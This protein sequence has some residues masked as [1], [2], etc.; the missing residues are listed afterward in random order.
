VEGHMSSTDRD[1]AANDDRRYTVFVRFPDQK[2]AQR[3]MP[4]GHTTN[5][6]VHAAILTRKEAERAAGLSRDY[7]DKEHPGS[8]VWIAP[9]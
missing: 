5:R 2:R 4:N 6:R 1:E 8:K 3:I 7:L 9:F